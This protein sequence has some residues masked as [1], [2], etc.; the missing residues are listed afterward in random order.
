MNAIFLMKNHVYYT[1][2]E[3]ID[4]SFYFVREILKEDDLVLEKIHT[5]ENPT[6]MLTK[7]ISEAKFNHC[8]NLLHI[9][10]VA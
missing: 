8:K 5:Q 10:P 6:D 1:R 7:V 2:T 4:D 9:F 3:H